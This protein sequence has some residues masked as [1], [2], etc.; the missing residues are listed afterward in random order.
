MDVI[1]NHFSKLY[2]YQHDYTKRQLRDISDELVRDGKINIEVYDHN[3]DRLVSRGRA[4]LLSEWWNMRTSDIVSALLAGGVTRLRARGR[5]R[6]TK[7][8][9]FESKS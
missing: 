8:G 4:K 5:K 1:Y 9:E 6:Q 7:V 3:Y 2:N